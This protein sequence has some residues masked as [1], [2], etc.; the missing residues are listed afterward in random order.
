[1]ELQLVIHEVQQGEHLF[2]IARQSGFRNP[3][4]MESPEQL[5]IYAI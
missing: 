1:M 4:N 3:D 2:R 5:E